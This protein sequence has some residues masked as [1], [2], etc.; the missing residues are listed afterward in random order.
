MHQDKILTE[1]KKVIWFFDDLFILMFHSKYK[2]IN[3]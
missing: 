3:S 2:Y 1:Q